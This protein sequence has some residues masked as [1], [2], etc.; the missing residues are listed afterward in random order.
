MPTLK[1]HEPGDIPSP[2]I[3]VASARS[4][5]K[6]PMPATRLA[7]RKVHG[8]GNDFILISGSPPGTDLPRLARELCS[9]QTGIGAD[10]LI[11]STQ[12]APGS[13]AYQ[14]RC[15]NP[16]GSEATMCGNALRCTALC[17]AAD[18][19]H[20]QVSMLMAGVWHQGEIRDREVAVTAGVGQVTRSVATA[21]HDDR[22]FEFDLVHTGT[23]HVIAFVPDVDAVDVGGFGCLVRYH[24]RFA[25]VGT[26]VNFV[27]VISRDAMRIRT[28][29]RGVE[30][31]TLSCGSGAV[32]AV[33]AARGRR[34]VSDG[35]VT[36]D[37]R[38]QAPLAVWP[39]TRHDRTFWIAGPAVIVFRGEI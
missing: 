23:E 14:V 22:T 34:L 19:G 31:E 33:V 6:T 9:R 4:A 28:Y 30:A 29:E 24:Q 16:D 32:A 26:N 36:V 38:A 3:R 10:G 27:Q 15:I 1:A 8:A 21:G 12:R 25:P 11:V 2:L 5:D 7:F 17:A 35:R 13:P 37:N 39:D 20:V 18:H